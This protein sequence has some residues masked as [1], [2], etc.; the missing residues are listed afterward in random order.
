MVVLHLAAPNHP[1]WREAAFSSMAARQ[2]NTVQESIRKAVMGSLPLPGDCTPYLA[3]PFF[4][5]EDDEIRRRAHCVGGPN[6]RHTWDLTVA[7]V[8]SSFSGFAWQRDAPLPTVAGC[9]QTAIEPL[10]LRKHSL[11]LACAGRTDAGVSA[12]GQRV[13][14]PAWPEIDADDLAAAIAAAA[15]QDGALR[16]VQARRTTDRSYHA[17]FSCRWRR[18]CYLLPPSPGATR[19][20]VELEATRI[21]ALL[22]PLAGVPRDFAAFGRGLPRN[23]PTTTRLWHA[24]ARTVQL[25]VANEGVAPTC[26]F[27]TRIDLVGD[28]FI[29][30]Q[31]RTIVATAAAAAGGYSET[32]PSRVATLSGSET[33][34][35]LGTS[36]P[37]SQWQQHTAHPAPALGL[38]FAAAGDTE[39]EGDEAHIQRLQQDPEVARTWSWDSRAGSLGLGPSCGNRIE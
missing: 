14:F 13:S 32:T 39:V 22:R 35:L 4:S 11:R 9:L 30:R 7:Y 24:S 23:K 29:R 25:P 18:Y 1:D 12:L 10:L 2:W 19:G 5:Q 27:A 26:P 6:R 16:L 21:D 37:P 33:T 36:G 34:P 15:P 28:R 31:V 17:T 3:S 8:G 38:C 20:D